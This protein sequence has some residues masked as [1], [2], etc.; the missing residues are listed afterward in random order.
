[1]AFTRAIIILLIFI[2]LVIFRL[3]PLSLVLQE[4]LL[5]KRLELIKQLVKERL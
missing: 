2:Q 1:M 4:Q 3:I 5:I